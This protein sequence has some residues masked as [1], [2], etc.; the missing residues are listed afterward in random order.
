MLMPFAL[1]HPVVSQQGLCPF[2]P[3]PATSGCATGPP[4]YS[5]KCPIMMEVTLDGGL[6]LLTVLRKGSLSSHG[7]K[8]AI[9]TCLQSAWTP[10]AA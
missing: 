6:V 9:H 5:C 2:M 3:P 1:R 10:S 8:V 7:P 4:L